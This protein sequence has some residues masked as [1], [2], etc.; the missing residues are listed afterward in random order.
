[1]YTY[2]T[3]MK[4]HLLSSTSLFPKTWTRVFWTSLSKFME[5]FFCLEYPFFFSVSDSYTYSTISL[6]STTSVKLTSSSPHSII[7]PFAT[8]YNS[9]YYP[10][11]VSDSPQSVFYIFLTPRILIIH[12]LFIFNSNKSVA[13]NLTFKHKS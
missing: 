12:L 1:M 2:K 11:A 8:V 7:G 10:V 5:V 6:K 4:S 9:I 13:Q 3:S